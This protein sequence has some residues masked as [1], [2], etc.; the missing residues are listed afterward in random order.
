MEKKIGRYLWI[1]V[2][3]SLMSGCSYLKFP[4]VYKIAIRQGNVINQEMIDKLEAGMTP[5]QVR[6]VLGTPLVDDPFAV[7]RW[8]YY[9][10]YANPRGK[11]FQH[12]VT[13]YFDNERLAKLETSEKFT[14]PQSLGGKAKEEEKVAVEE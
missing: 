9:Y 13:V 12:Q 1:A 5:R 3:I 2:F 10:S 7:S 11:A 6:F 8:D 14:L 4:G